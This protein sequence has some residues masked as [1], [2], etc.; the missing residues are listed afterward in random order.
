MLYVKSSFWQSPLSRHSVLISQLRSYWRHRLICV[1]F[2]LC[3]FTICDIFWV[4]LELTLTVLQLKIL[5][6]LFARGKCASFNCKNLF[7]TFI[8]IF[9]LKVGLN[10]VIFRVF[11]LLLFCC[12]FGCLYCCFALQPHFFGALSQSGCDYL[13]ILALEEYLDNLPLIVWVRWFV[14]DGLIW[15]W[16]MLVFLYSW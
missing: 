12:K 5:C 11:L 2:L 8:F 15:C 3:F 4:Q 7:A 6:N 9:K 1:T 10:Q 14:T 13:N 16:C